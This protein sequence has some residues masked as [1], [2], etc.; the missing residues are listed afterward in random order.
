MS[1]WVM[2]KVLQTK[3]VEATGSRNLHILN[4]SD[5]KQSDIKIYRPGF[6]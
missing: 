2:K 4:I 3:S 1:K 5:Y 6:C